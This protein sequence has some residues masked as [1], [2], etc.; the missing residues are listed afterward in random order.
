MYERNAG[1]QWTKNEVQALKKMAQQN[2]PTRVAAFKLGRPV[3]SVYSQASKNHISLKP[4]NQ[5]PYNRKSR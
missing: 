1:K 4:N 3:S 5:S 2:T